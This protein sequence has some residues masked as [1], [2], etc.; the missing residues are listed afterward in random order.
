MRLPK[1]SLVAAACLLAATTSF[2]YQ[3]IQ[4]LDPTE[5]V[6][7]INGGGTLSNSIGDPGKI[8][9]ILYNPAGGSLIQVTPGLTLTINSEY[10]TTLEAVFQELG[11]TDVVDMLSDANGIVSK[12]DGAGNLTGGNVTKVGPRPSPASIPMS[13]ASAAPARRRSTSDPRSPAIRMAAMP[14]A[15]TGSRAPSPSTR[16]PCACPA[17]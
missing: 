3:N 8:N 11:T 15:S 14:S 4:V 9:N 7:V 2:A 17:S 12:T 5:T 10:A 16:A 13:P 6:T 1:S